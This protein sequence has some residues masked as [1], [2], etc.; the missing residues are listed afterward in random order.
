MKLGE[1]LA[2]SNSDHT[3]TLVNS[4]HINGVEY[5]VIKACTRTKLAI[6]SYFLVTN[7]TVILQ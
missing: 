5:V 2:T 3:N 7:V 6:L 4:Q 1:V